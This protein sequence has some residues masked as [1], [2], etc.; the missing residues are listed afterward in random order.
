MFKFSIRQ[1]MVMLFKLSCIAG[2]SLSF[3]S[4]VV[5]KPTDANALKIDESM[6]NWNLVSSPV[7][8]NLRSIAMTSANDGW[9]VGDSGIILH[10]NGSVWGQ[11][12]SP[13]SQPLYDLKML[14]AMNGWPWAGLGPS[15]I[16]MGTHGV[17]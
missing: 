14:S 17:W 2:I 6:G 1:Y 16:G 9:A 12:N 5:V 10:W 11:A 3:S 15:C 13:T 7:S 8:A 4:F